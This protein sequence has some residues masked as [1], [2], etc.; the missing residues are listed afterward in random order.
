M[1]TVNVLSKAPI[2]FQILDEIQKMIILDRIK[3]NAQIPSVLFLS[4]KLSINANTVQKTYNKLD[5]QGI[6]Y[7]VLGVGRFVSKDA[8]T[9]LQK[10]YVGS[11]AELREAIFNMAIAG[12]DENKVIAIIKNSYDLAKL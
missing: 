12:V 1:L 2:Y 5:I 9:L 7:S 8:K 11:L 3:P 10:Q 6:T 4:R